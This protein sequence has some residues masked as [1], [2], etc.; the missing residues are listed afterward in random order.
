[1]LVSWT[2][3]IRQA[4]AI[5]VHRR[6]GEG[7]DRGNEP[8]GRTPGPSQIRHFDW[9]SVQGHCPRPEVVTPPLLSTGYSRHVIVPPSIRGWEIQTPELLF[10]Q[11]IG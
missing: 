1:M 10:Y 9:M 8:D 4:L 7:R 6:D 2:Q 5:L 3:R 11:L